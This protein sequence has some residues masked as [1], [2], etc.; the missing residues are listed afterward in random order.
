[1]NSVFEALL[2]ISIFTVMIAFVFSNVKDTLISNLQQ[3][4][5]SSL[6][7]KG[8]AIA[9]LLKL[10]LEVDRDALIEIKNLNED[11]FRKQ[12]IYEAEILSGTQTY[13]TIT[14]YYIR[15]QPVVN[16]ILERAESKTELT[17]GGSRVWISLISFTRHENTWLPEISVVQT[18]LSLSK[19]NFAVLSLASEAQVGLVH[20]GLEEMSGMVNVFWMEVF[21]LKCLSSKMMSSEVNEFVRS[22]NSPC[23]VVEYAEDKIFYTFVPDLCPY[24]E[25]GNRDYPKNAV[26]VSEIARVQGAFCLIEVYLWGD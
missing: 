14:G 5:F 3:F 15:I 6:E 20:K 13:K 7:Q 25:L 16:V 22:V 8:Y 1:M 12:F 24:V 10:W 23:L 2:T 17:T 21:S 9:S 4:Q 19:D 18:P 26:R 11:D